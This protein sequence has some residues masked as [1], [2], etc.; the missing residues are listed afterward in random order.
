MSFKPTRRFALPLLLAGL[1]GVKHYPYTH[2]GELLKP[3]YSPLSPL[4]GYLRVGFPV[5]HL[6]RDRLARHLARNVSHDLFVASLRLPLFPLPFFLALVCR[7]PVPVGR[8]VQVG[9]EKVQRD[10][11]DDGGVLFCSDLSHRLKQPQLQGCGALQPISSL[12]EALG[13][14]KLALCRYDLCS[15]LALA[16]GLAC[17]RP[18]HILRDLH[19]LDFNHTDLHAPRLGL[20]VYYLL[21]LLVYGLTVGQEI[22]ETFLTQDAPQRGLGDLAG[23][24]DMVLYLDDALVRVHHP[25]VDHC[26]YARGDVVAGDEILGRDV[27]GDGPQA[28]LNHPVHHRDQDEQTRPLG[29]SLYPTEPEDHTPL[30]LL[31]YLDGAYQDKQDDRNHRYQH[32]G[33]KPYS[34][35]LQQAQDRVHKNSPFALILGVE[36][37]VTLG[38]LNGHYLHHSSITETHHNDLSSCL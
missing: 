8:R 14:L 18:L 28:N 2:R 32:D 25:E 21:K 34:D 35:Q 10:G 20:L 26:G 12:P 27:H 1:H 36:D 3:S 33:R 30:I 19:V 23:C 17:H 37:G 16:L 11:Q 31:D 13:G 29:S 9:L 24:Q 38:P 5:R 15:P 22:V 4:R 6:G 7:N